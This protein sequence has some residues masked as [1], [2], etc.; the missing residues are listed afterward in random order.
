MDGAPPS[1]KGSSALSDSEGPDKKTHSTKRR[2]SFFSLDTD[3]GDSHPLL[4]DTDTKKKMSRRF[5]VGQGSARKATQRPPP[6]ATPTPVSPPNRPQQ[7][8]PNPTQTTKYTLVTD[9]ITASSH[10]QANITQPTQQE[11]AV[12]GDQQQQ[13][14]T[15]Q[16]TQPTQQHQSAEE[17]QTAPQNQDQPTP[18]KS[19]SLNAS[20][21]KK[22]DNQQQEVV[23]ARL[24]GTDEK[25]KLAKRPLIRRAQSVGSFVDKKF[26]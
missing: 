9:D 7:P 18:K 20:A 4:P 6:S 26:R 14:N 10:Q 12:D 24:P 22:G 15:T 13:A 8:I 1:R 3:G 11:K 16:T 17:S 2:R 21:S 23:S 5:S 25:E 19:I